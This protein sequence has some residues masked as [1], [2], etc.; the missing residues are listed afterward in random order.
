MPQNFS[1]SSFP[2]PNYNQWQYS[3]FMDSCGTYLD[4][5]FTIGGV[6]TNS[7]IAQFDK[8]FKNGKKGSSTK[9]D[10]TENDTAL[11]SN[12]IISIQESEKGD[13]IQI[14][15][16][17]DNK[18]Q[19]IKITIYN[20]LGKKVMELYQGPPKDS[21]QPY[22]LITSDLPKGIFLIVV[23]GDNFRLREKLIISR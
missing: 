16:Q 3:L 1:Q 10:L 4:F 19:N 12:R 11:K 13:K 18:E 6:K 17:V 8:R 22:E 9:N 2:S 20:L 21:N 7:K 23:S 5:L 14:Y 15:I